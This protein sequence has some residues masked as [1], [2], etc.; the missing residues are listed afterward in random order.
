MKKT[1]LVFDLSSLLWPAF[2]AGVDKEHGIDVDHNGRKVRVNGVDHVY[3]NIINSMVGYCTHYNIH[4]K[5]C[6]IVVEGAGNKV[7]RQ[8]IYAGYKVSS[9]KPKEAYDV[10]VAVRDR[11]LDVWR[12]LGATAIRQDGCEADDVLGW[13][14]KYS[15]NNLILASRDNDILVLNGTNEYGATIKTSGDNYRED[16]NPYGMFPMKFITVYKAMVGDSGDKIPGIPGFGPQAWIDFDREFGDAGL[17]EME[18]LAQLG[19]L[20]DLA[21]DAT[22][23]K[24]IHKIYVNSDS[25]LKCYALAK[26][27]PEWVNQVNNP[28]IWMPGFPNPRN[29]LALADERL[30]K[31]APAMRLV[32]ADNYD[33]AVAWMKTKLAESPE[34]ALDFETATPPESDDWLASRDAENKVDVIASRITGMS[35]S[36]GNNGQYCFYVSVNHA[37]TNNVTKEQAAAILAMLEPEKLKIAHGAQNFELAVAKMEF[38]DLPGFKDNGWRGFIPNM[39]D[40]R[41]AATHWDENQYQFGLK[42]LSLKLFGYEQQ[43]YDEVTQGRKMDEVPAVE[44][45]NYGCDDSYTAYGLWN[46][47]SLFMELEGTLPAFMEFEQK[48]MYLQAVGFINGLPLDMGRLNK[49]AKADE[50]SKLR[51]QAILDNYLIAAGWDGTVAPVADAENIT[52]SSFVKHVFNIVTGEELK[53]AVRTPSKLY[54]A[55]AATGLDDA[56][57][58]AAFFQAGDIDGINRMIRLH[59]TARPEFNI[60]SSKQKQDLLYGTMKLPVRLRN[61]PTDTMKAKG[62]REGGARTDDDAIN[63]AIKQKDCDEYT[64]Q[65]LKAM[66]ELSSINTRTSLYWSAYPKMIH[67]HTGKIHP[68][69]RQSGTN[70]RRYTASDP[71]VQ[72]QEGSYGGVRSTLLP[73]KRNAVIVSLDESAQEVRQLADYCK[74]PALL[75]CYIGDA[76]QLRDVHSIVGSK[77]AGVSYDEF[78]TRYKIEE[79]ERNLPD[80][81]KTYPTLFLNI[82]Q[83]AKITLFATIYG[84]AAPKIAEGLGISVEEAQGY[85]DAIYAQFPGVLAWKEESEEMAR[86]YGFVPIHGGTIRHLAPL[87]NSEDKYI[88]SKAMR[89]AGN[90]RI[91]SA[92]G[93]QIKR[94]MSRIWDSNLL[95]DYDY[96]WYF[97]VHDE[98]VHSVSIED[99]VAVIPILHGFMTEQFLDVVPSASS[100]GIGKNFG[101]LVELGETVDLDKI[102]A[103]LQKLF[104]K[105]VA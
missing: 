25:F 41:I 52:V 72:Q 103:T 38:G 73:H 16:H 83:H 7:P 84:A 31:W 12:G 82:R 13:L 6:I 98:T 105:E 44:V 54:D 18:R 37:N 19:N 1:R 20:N 71:N 91:Q 61:R 59:F 33:A 76:S 14:A 15:R 60:G 89:Q 101:E 78:R 87:V 93:N 80:V 24:G 79:K 63:M 90:S 68:S 3:E 49:L 10:F 32:T 77:I 42:H 51:Y 26:L 96:Q 29:A 92:G 86:T 94:I 102:K 4:P 67:W 99:A 11:V 21:M 30:R 75:T 57:M 97:S 64:E 74:D 47:F 5:D 65:T 58:L 27:H 56:P 70:T 23:H 85:I 66:M 40:T 104:E 55:I 95:D 8:A 43:T 34:Y 9:G 45:L 48:P 46:F 35:I 28:L 39:V 22:Q 81:E 17:A 100:I 88:A 62:I 36:F 2:Y 53:T 69:L 50:E